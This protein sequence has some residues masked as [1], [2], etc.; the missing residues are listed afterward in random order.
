MGLRSFYF[1]LVLPVRGLTYR[2][3]ILT[4]KV[5]PRAERVNCWALLNSDNGYIYLYIYL[6]HDA[7]I[8]IYI[9]AH[10]TL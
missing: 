9:T 3:E 6:Y 8:L 1:I 2:R 10:D 5:D 7:C 4:S